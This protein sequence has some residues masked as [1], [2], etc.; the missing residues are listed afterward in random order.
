MMT[1]KIVTL[2]NITIILF[3]SIIFIVFISFQESLTKEYASN[4]SYMILE[5]DTG[6]PVKEPCFINP[7]QCQSSVSG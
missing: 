1:N 3:I 5:P 4:K 2:K 7:Q 6:E